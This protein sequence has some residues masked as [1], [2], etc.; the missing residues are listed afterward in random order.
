M[1]K[2]TFTRKEVEYILDLVYD[3]YKIDKLPKFC[4]E[5]LS[6]YNN[7]PEPDQISDAINRDITN[8]IQSLP[9]KI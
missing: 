2:N 6:V 5:M 8:F 7:W 9:D 4:E 1:P 3:Y